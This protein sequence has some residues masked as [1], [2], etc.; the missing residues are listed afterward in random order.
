M[1]IVL[2]YPFE[3]YV[4]KNVFFFAFGWI[5]EL[6]CACVKIEWFPFRRNVHF[7]F[8][9]LIIIYNVIL[10]FALFN[11]SLTSQHINAIGMLVSFFCSVFCS[12]RGLK[13][14]LELSPQKPTTIK[15]DMTVCYCLNVD[16]TLS[17][18]SFYSSYLF[19]LCVCVLLSVIRH[20]FHDDGKESRAMS[21]ALPFSPCT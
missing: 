7:A 4:R 15:M 16:M 5:L 21:P 8:L 10:T 17:C 11:V 3:M 2:Q 19:S 9:V 12:E 18:C 1:F 6:N 13:F 20:N 14:E